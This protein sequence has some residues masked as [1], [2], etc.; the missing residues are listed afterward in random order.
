MFAADDH[1]FYIPRAV[2]VVERYTMEKIVCPICGLGDSEKAIEDSGYSGM[3]CKACQVIYVS[4]RPDGKEMAELY[5]HGD[6]H[7]S[8]ETHMAASRMKRRYARHNLSIIMKHV[9]GGRLLEVGSGAGFFL[10][11]ARKR[12]YDVRGI[13]LN[14]SQAS[15]IRE[16]FGI[17][18]EESPLSPASFGGERFDVI[19]HCDVLSHFPD[20]VGEL[21]KMR[22]RLGPGG[23]M[24]FETG[25]IGEIERRHYSVFTTFQYPDHLFFFGSA[26]IKRLLEMA[27]FEIVKIYRYSILAQL[28]MMKRLRGKG[29][30]SERQTD[31]GGAGASG[32]SSIK[33]LVR[34][35]YGLYSYVIRYKWGSIA[36]KEGRPQTLIVV[37][38]PA[39]SGH[40]V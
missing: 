32:D 14:P 9:P 22:Q 38:R 37:A 27:G 11:E 23:I 17:E 35:V 15:F 10:D 12:G 13:E 2:W 30:Y 25:N 7:V 29:K 5:S 1:H 34:R 8:P 36:P 6:A 28:R 33:R 20:P 26:S 40:E 24:V 39:A 18:V 16:R 3:K 19:Y 31:N 21:R 4:P